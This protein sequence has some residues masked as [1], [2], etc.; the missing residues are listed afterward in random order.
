MSI[1]GESKLG[2]DYLTVESSFGSVKGFINKDYPNVAQFLGIRFAEPPTGPRRWLPPVAKAPADHIDATEFGPSPPQWSGKNASVYNT[3]VPEL[4]IKDGT[5]ED[6]L[7]LCIYVP[8]KAAKDP[9]SAKLPVI[10]WIT[11]GAFLVGGN[12]IPYQNPTPWVNRSQRHIV[13][14]IKYAYD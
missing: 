4:R 9:K 5:S 7:S 11:G 8:E 13:V 10:V 3:D 14:S 6:C 2:V 1:I 12:T